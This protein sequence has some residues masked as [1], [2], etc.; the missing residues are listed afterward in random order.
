MQMKELWENIN[1]LLD[2]T[3][4]SIA[5]ISNYLG[6]PVEWVEEVVEQRWQDA[7]AIDDQ[8]WHEAIK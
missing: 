4:W 2:T 5:E 3:R 7:I 8:R 6:C 1:Y